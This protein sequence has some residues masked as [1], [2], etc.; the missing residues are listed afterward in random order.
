MADEDVE[1]KASEL[2]GAEKHLQEI[3]LTPDEERNLYEAFLRGNESQRK[4]AKIKYNIALA[5]DD[6]ATKTQVVEA[7]KALLKEKEV[8]ENKIKELN[9]AAK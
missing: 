2:L 1:K 8:I 7:V 5:V 4:Q 6:K 9:D 3:A